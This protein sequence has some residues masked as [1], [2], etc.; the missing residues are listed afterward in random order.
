MAQH[1]LFMS[2]SHVING[3]SQTWLLIDSFSAVHAVC[4]IKVLNG[5]HDVNRDDSSILCSDAGAQ[6]HTQKGTVTLLP[7]EA[8]CNPDGITNMLS[9][10]AVRSMT[11]AKVTMDTSKDP[12]KLSVEIPDADNPAYDNSDCITTVTNNKSF[13]TRKKAI[14]P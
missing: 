5:D 9:F 3:I 7:L 8:Y 10:K 2:Q 1:G 12:D 14:W 6:T 4:N 11:G 13:F